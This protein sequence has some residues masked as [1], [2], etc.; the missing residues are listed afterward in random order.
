M[1]RIIARQV[2]MMKLL[3][4]GKNGQVGRELQ[5]ELINFSGAIF[6]DSSEVDFNDL[7]SIRE[8][9]RLQRPDIIIN[10]AAYTNVEAA[11]NAP[12]QAYRINA[13]AVEIIAQEAKK[14]NA[15][16]IHYS[17]DYVFDG[18][19]KSLYDENDTPRPLNIYGLSKL[20]G[21]HAI[22]KTGCKH[23]IFRTS[24]V[25]SEH[26]KNFAKTILDLAKTSTN[27]QIV[28]DQI[29][30]PTH[31]HMIANVTEH[32]IQEIINRQNTAEVLV[33]IYNISCAGETSWHGFAE[34]LLTQVG[35]DVARTLQATSSKNYK[36]SV[37]RPANSRLDT[38]KFI[39]TFNLEL[40]HWE[41][42]ALRFV[43]S[44]NNDARTA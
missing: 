19:K 40:P 33:G 18:C 28:N 36:T 21:E 15:W 13:E 42:Y 8:C 30:A 44:M 41:K 23:I 32:V 35:V 39:N 20:A 38:S 14:L 3:L 1:L 31:A 6:L 11:E 5:Q 10:A 7:D 25:F 27:L 29:G 26:G 12:L 9:L 34:F 24:W 37:N 16:F 4:F 17:T 43:E 22:Q 2:C